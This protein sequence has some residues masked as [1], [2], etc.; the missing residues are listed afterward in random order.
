MKFLSIIVAA[1]TLAAAT[2]LAVAQDKPAADA[3]ATASEGTL[4][5]VIVTGTRRIDRT[6]AESSAPIDVLS[7]ADLNTQPTGNMLDTL[8]NMVPSFIVGQNSISDASSF[9]RSPSL[10]GLPARRDAGDAERQTHEP[11]RAGAGLPGRRDGTGVRLAGTGPRLDSVHRGQDP[12]DP[13]RRR[14]GA[15]RLGR[16]RRR[17]QLP[18]QDNASG[19]EIDGRYGEYFPERL[20]ERRRRRPG[21]G[22]HRP[23]AGQPGFRQLQRRMG[24]ERADRPQPDAPVGP[25]VRR[26]LSRASRPDCRTTRVRYS[27]GARH[28][29]R[30]SRRCS[31]PASSSTTATSSISSPTTPIS[32]R[33][34]ASTIACRRP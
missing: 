31:M 10:R 3:S 18:V 6:V 27:S 9:V 13:A 19:I 17:A 22:Q 12:R 34:R 29:R 11:L 21:G 7:G 16:D 26:K 33:T 15:V 8:S 30:A 28:R 20:H 1:A 24:Q 23:A 25:G 4:G 32:R 5:E 14:L 2:N